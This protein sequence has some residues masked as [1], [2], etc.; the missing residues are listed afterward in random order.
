[1]PN[2]K[3]IPKIRASPKHKEPIYDGAA[4]PRHHKLSGGASR[5][6]LWFKFLKA[7]CRLA[8]K[9]LIVRIAICDA[10]DWLFLHK[11]R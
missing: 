1:V 2:L 8:F 5:R 3:L 11:S 9:N 4:K 6:H 10:E 7:I